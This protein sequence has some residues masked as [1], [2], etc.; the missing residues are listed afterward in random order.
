MKAELTLGE[1]IEDLI[2]ERSIKREEVIK[3]AGISRET[4]GRIINDPD[5]DCR[6][7]NIVRLC[8]YFNVSADYLLGLSESK[9]IEADKKS[10]AAVTGLTDKAIEK[11]NE[12]VV[13]GAKDFGTDRISAIITNEKFI[14]FLYNIMKALEIERDKDIPNDGQLGQLYLKQQMFERIGKDYSSKIMIVAGDRLKKV[15]ISDAKE[16]MSKIIDDIVSKEK[17]I[18]K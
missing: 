14:E 3:K 5:N 15:Y 1:K 13:A 12:F 8:K 4:L 17:E 6:I 10:A 18:D 9:Y 11:L 16:T 7:S 2:K